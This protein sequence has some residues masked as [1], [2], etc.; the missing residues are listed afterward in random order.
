MINFGH[1][2]GEIGEKVSFSFFS[3]TLVF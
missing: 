2:K 1:T 3:E